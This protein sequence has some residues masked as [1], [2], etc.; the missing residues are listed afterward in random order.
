[1]N[2]SGKDFTEGRDNPYRADEAEAA[3]K[4]LT[5]R[6]KFS[7][8]LRIALGFLVTFIMVCG[9]TITAMIFIG[10]WTQNCS[11]SRQ[12]EI[13]PLKSSRHAALRRITSFTEPTF[14]ML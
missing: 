2:H 3:Q 13:M 14:T 9:I 12:P 4:A 5:R 11:F 1:M 7:I 10:R 8:R 6:P